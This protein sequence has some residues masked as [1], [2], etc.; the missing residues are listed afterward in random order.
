MTAT[1]T[2]PQFTQELACCFDDGPNAAE[3][4][5]AIFRDGRRTDCTRVVRMEGVPKVKTLDRLHVPVGGFDLL[6]PRGPGD[7][8]AWL[9][10]HAV[11]VE[12]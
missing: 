4:R 2:K 11:E 10:D 12:R 6:A 3:W 7:V 5:Y 1:A 8:Q 9:A